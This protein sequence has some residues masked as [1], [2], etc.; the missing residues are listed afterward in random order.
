MSESFSFKCEIKNKKNCLL[1]NKRA[2]F[3]AGIY[4]GKMSDHNYS[5][6]F[7]SE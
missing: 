1:N 4:K 7:P 3:D 6:V 2:I 5:G